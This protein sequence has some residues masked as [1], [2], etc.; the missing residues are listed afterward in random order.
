MLKAW[1]A[2]EPFERFSEG[3]V[4]YLNSHLDFGEGL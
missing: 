1:E 4:K 2:V 3:D